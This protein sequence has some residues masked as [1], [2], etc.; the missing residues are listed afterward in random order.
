MNLFLD[1]GA[2][3]AIKDEADT[4]HLQAIHFNRTSIEEKR[5]L[6]TTDYVLD[7]TYTL[8]K[9]RAGYH[10]AKQFGEEIR[11]SELLRIIYITPE[12]FEE[13]W[14]IFVKCQDQPFSFTDCTS[15]AIMRKKRISA[16]FAFDGHFE[17]YG[18]EQLPR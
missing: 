13:A 9:M 5:E 8:L 3:V 12:I 17:K 4:H 15:F 7:E 6:I 16:A 11:R 2:F 10:V 14:Q 18:F 1:T